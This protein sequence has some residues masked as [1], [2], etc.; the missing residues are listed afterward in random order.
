MRYRLFLLVAIK[1]FAHTHHSSSELF[2]LRKHNNTEVVRL[3]PVKATAGDKKNI[4][5]VEKIPCEFLIISD[6]EL[7][8]IKLGEEIE[9]GTVGWLQWW[10]PTL[11]CQDPLLNKGLD[12][13]K[14]QFPYL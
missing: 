13:S 3:F 2:N 5:S 7:F 8:D 9:G 12:L 14:P 1:E 4:C 10:A 6:V 11:D